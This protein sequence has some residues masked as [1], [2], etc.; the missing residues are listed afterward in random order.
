MVRFPMRRAARTGGSLF[1]AATP[2]TG[3]AISLAVVAVA[4]IET[5]GAFLGALILVR[6][7][8]QVADF[9]S[10]DQLL[11]AFSRD[12]GDIAGS[13]ARNLAARAWLLLAGPV[14]FALAGW[15]PVQVA[16]MSGW[17]VALFLGQ[18]A[19]ALV[20]YRRAFG[21][22][23]ALE[24]A[25]T[26]AICGLVLVAGAGASVELLLV[27]FT[28]AAAV[29]T[30]VLLVRLDAFAALR[31]AM[32]LRPAPSLLREAWPFFL[33]SF[34]GA[35]QS[36]VDLYLVALLLPAAGLGAYGIVTNFVLL[37]HAMA[38][39]L[40]APMAPALYRMPRPGVLRAARRLALA[41]VPASLAGIAVTAFA[42]A[43]LYRIEVAPAALM[44][45]W[46]AML[47]PFGYAPLVILWFRAGRERVVIAV[48]AAATLVTA[49]GTLALAP[50]LGITG[51]LASMA[52]G[53]VFVAAAHA[54]L[55]RHPGARDV[56]AVD[57]SAAAGPRV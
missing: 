38:A 43:Y 44:A 4:G 2:A 37:V 9:G 42:L 32:L 7:C 12:P 48:A 57:A 30:G 26:V 50:G 27:A 5:W 17:L 33:L 13:W 25:G 40:L 51:A 14:V 55:L 41:G 22:A 23:A 16:L 8:A 21:L 18:M 28:L 46:I 1:L 19:A 56:R 45:A 52:A 10:R 3:A 39:A 11:R 47:P 31:P 35:I 20:T 53:Q 49:I 15:S 6:L 36:R 54:V 34:T 29:R 24:L